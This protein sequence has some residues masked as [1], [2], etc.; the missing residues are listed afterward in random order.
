MKQVTFLGHVISKEGVSIDFS[1]I[2][3]V[4][5]RPRLTNASEILSFLG[6]AGYYHRFIQNFSSI[7]AP[8]ETGKES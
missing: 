7:A 8:N 3:T 6:L 5:E 2:T 1:K 4:V